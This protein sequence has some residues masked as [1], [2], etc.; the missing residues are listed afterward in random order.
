M[1][2]G[3]KPEAEVRFE[4]M[5]WG[6]V[7]ITAA[8]LYVTLFNVLPSL[9]LFIPGLILL[10]GAIAQDLQEGWHAGAFSYILAI[11]IIATGLSGIINTLLGDAVTIPW[12]VVA[13]V[14]LGTVLLIKALY[15]PSL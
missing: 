8:V 2:R 13:V 4:L 5:V 9:M 3:N 12:L 10:G 11:V 6:L 7:L 15:D 14:E 1:L